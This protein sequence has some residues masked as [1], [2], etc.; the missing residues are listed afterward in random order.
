MQR[1]TSLS[2]AFSLISQTGFCTGAT[3]AST[4]AS[5]SMCATGAATGTGTSGTWTVLCLPLLRA[6]GWAWQLCRLFSGQFCTVMMR[7]KALRRRHSCRYTLPWMYM[8]TRP[9]VKPMPTTTS[10]VQ[11]GHSSTP[12]NT[13]TQSEPAARVRKRG[14]GVQ[15]CAYPVGNS[16]SEEKLSITHLQSRVSVVS[17]YFHD[18]GIL[19][20]HRV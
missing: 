1:C 4:D 2:S 14:G 5:E 17:L 6:L 12:K 9:P 3:A 18:L 10:L 15:G 11:K 16:T 8:K 19:A 13:Q 20:V 7:L